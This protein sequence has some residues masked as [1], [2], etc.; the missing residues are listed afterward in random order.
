MPSV[1]SAAGLD[2]SQFIEWHRRLKGRLPRVLATSV[3]RAARS[4]R[5]AMG[6]AVRADV[7]SLKASDVNKA[8]RFIPSRPS[9]DPVARIKTPQKRL[10]LI[11]FGAKQLKRAGVRTRLRGGT[12]TIKGAFIAKGRRGTE[13]GGAEQV[14][15]RSGSGG[16]PIY[17]LFGP[18]L[19]K[20]FSR[21]WRSV[22]VPRYREQIS[23]EIASGLANAARR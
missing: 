14:F 13:S 9:L 20:P 2:T 21:H 15:K 11:K 5:T 18:S 12:K 16:L 23:K 4:T 8:I 1:S 3:N 6:R 19:A 10:S 22:G 17:K 7:G